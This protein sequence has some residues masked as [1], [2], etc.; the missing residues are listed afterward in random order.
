MIPAYIGRVYNSHVGQGHQFVREGWHME[1][2]ITS[3]AQIHTYGQLN[4]HVLCEEAGAPG[5]NLRR[6]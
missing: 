1:R 3:H 5:G 4:L 2:Q 6:G